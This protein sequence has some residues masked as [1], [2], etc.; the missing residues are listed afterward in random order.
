MLSAINYNRI[1]PTFAAVGL[2]AA[3]ASAPWPLQP[4]SRY[5]STQTPSTHGVVTLRSYDGFEAVNFGQRIVDFLAAFASDQ[6]PLGREMEEIW[7][8]NT[9]S[10]YEA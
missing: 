2:A 7:D 10:L 5:H 8:A 9:E 4:T 6:Q 3:V 1:A